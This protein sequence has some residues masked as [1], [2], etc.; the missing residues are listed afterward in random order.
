MIPDFMS[1]IDTEQ[2]II[3]EIDL[4][5]AEGDN[6][7]DFLASYR[8]G[9]FRPS[10]IKLVYR[11]NRGASSPYWYL[12]QIKIRGG[13]VLSGGHRVST[14]FQNVIN[15]SFYPEKAPEW[16]REIGAMLK[17]T[18]EIERAGFGG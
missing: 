10:H 12:F 2:T 3:R 7:F 17:P 15:E 5:V 18:V 11:V 8:G 9:N 4:A 1:I 13:K 14:S 16:A 6:R